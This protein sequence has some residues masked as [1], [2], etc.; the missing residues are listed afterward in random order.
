[1]NRSQIWSALI[2]LAVA[3][4]VLESAFIVPEGLQAA[5]ETRGEPHWLEPGL[6]FRWPIGQSL[7]WRDLR[8]H[9]LGANGTDKAPYVRVTTFDQKNLE[10]GYAVL[11]RIDTPEAYAKAFQTEELATTAIRVLINQAL[12][13]CCLSQTLVQWLDPQSL[14]TIT[15]QAL[16]SAAVILAP[17]GI[18]LSQLAI[19][20]ISVPALERDEWLNGMKLRG[21][22]ALNELQMETSTLAAHL[23]TEVDNKVTQTLIDGKDQA[24]RVRANAD[25]QATDVYAAAY[26]KNPEFY[27]FYTNLKAYEQVFKA[28]KQV[29]VLSTHSPFLKSM[30]PS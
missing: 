17:Q 18:H 22:S 4:G 3:A 9:L 14:T 24:E 27:E 26:H 30:E 7:Q 15:A 25:A 1:M 20:N 10:L 23:Q 21:Q 2:L 11:W 19:T 28:Q 6:H 8:V 29:V 5:K 16:N 13:Q 12:S